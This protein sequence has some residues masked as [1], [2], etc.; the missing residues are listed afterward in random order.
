[1]YGFT[2]SR[3]DWQIRQ[4][5]RCASRPQVS[6]GNPG[7]AANAPVRREGEATALACRPQSSGW[8]QRPNAFR[9]LDP[10]RL[11]CSRRYEPGNERGEQL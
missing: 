2:R 11:R 8:R 4:R 5:E 7:R 1:M 6:R 3:V 9:D 10:R